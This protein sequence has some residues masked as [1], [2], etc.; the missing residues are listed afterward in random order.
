MVCSSNMNRSMEAHAV[1]GRAA[2]DVESYG[3]G[4]QVKLP[5]PSMHEP[6]VYD[7]GTPYGGIYDDLRRKDP[8]RTGLYEAQP[9][10]FFCSSGPRGA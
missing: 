5:G 6:N 4:S 10:A 2:L 1:L 9:A 7:F 8:D 3:T